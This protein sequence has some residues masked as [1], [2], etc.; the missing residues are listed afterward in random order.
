LKDVS[1]QQTRMLNGISNA[2][3][4][5]ELNGNTAR[6]QSFTG[7]TGGGKVTLTGTVSRAE[8]AFRFDLQ[9]RATEARVRTEAGVSVTSD[10]NIR[11]NGSDKSSLLSGDVDI[12]IVAFNARSDFGSLLSR[13][14]PPRATPSGGSFLDTVRLNIAGHLGSDTV[15]R[16]GFA[17]RLEANAD[18]SVRGTA[19]NPGML[20][21]IVISE[22][23]LLFFGTKYS[24]NDGVVAFYNPNRI[25]PILNL[26]LTTTARG[27]RVDLTVTGPV[28]NMSLSYRSDPPLQ[29]NEVVSL[30]AAGKAPT[31]D[32]VLVAHQPQTPQQTLPQMGA[33]ALLSAAVAD[34]VAGQL[35]R[36]FG[37]TQL[38][39]DPTFTSGSELPQARLTV[40]QQ[41]T[42][43]LT[44]TYVTNVA[45]S[46]SQIIRVEWAIDD[47]WS[48][49]ATRQENGMVAV[50]L[51]Y[52]RRFQ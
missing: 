13:V 43:S 36:V 3:A 30:L 29:F 34:P 45:R 18:V 38:K 39:I 47:D 42:P 31:S 48:A 44:F 5:I 24:L 8:G 51:F 11:F 52:R 20:G 32:P 16:T 27:V 14:A 23:E 33:S 19:A 15:F 50:D 17:E 41:I 6:I 21:R 25:D 1:F 22:G 26:N 9:A 4:V 7:E 46:D 35:Q 40:Q 49:L 28:A 37:V 10:A 12:R 2:N